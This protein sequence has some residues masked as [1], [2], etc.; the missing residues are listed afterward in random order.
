MGTSISQVSPG[1]GPG[2]NEWSNF[3]NDI[4][5]GNITP[6]KAL[7]SV[8]EAFKGEYGNEYVN[9]IVDKGVSLIENFVK[10]FTSPHN[11]PAEAAFIVQ[12]RKLLAQHQ[13]NSFLAEL[14]LMKAAACS[15]IDDIGKRKVAFYTNY[16]TGVVDYSV[17]RDLTKI[18]GNIGISNISKL[19][20]YINNV[21]RKLSET[22]TKQKSLKEILND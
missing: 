13:S 18:L 17:S 3:Q 11:I 20:S 8:K 12:G 16:L 1:S 14:A 10:K 21:K 19:E 4:S 2:S 22:I 7:S 6:D 15:S 5:S 9:I